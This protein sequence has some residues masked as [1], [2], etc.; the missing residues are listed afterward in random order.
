MMDKIRIFL[1]QCCG[2]ESG[3]VRIRII[4][5]DPDPFPVCLGSGSVSYSNGTT[6]LTGRENLTKNTFCVGP[7]DKENQVKMYK[8]LF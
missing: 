3:S 8:E 7:T 5:H 6:K 4:F 2:S 1:E